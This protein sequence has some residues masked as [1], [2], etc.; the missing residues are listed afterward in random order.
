MSQ[1]PSLAVVIEGGLVQY[2][3]VQD[4]PASLPLP[5]VAVVDY[6]T[7]GA[8]DE[9]VTRF[10]LAGETLEALCYSETPEVYEPSA[11]VLSPRALLAA[12]G[13]A[14]DDGQARLSLAPRHEGTLMSDTPPACG[15]L[16]LD[17]VTPVII[18]L[19][20]ALGLTEA[21]PGPGPARVAV[22][23]ESCGPQWAG[24]LKALAHLAA[25]LDLVPPE[26]NGAFSAAAV[27]STLAAHFGVAREKEM[28]HLIDY[29][30]FEDTAD[31]NTLFMIA[32]HFDDGHGLTSLR[33]ENGWRD[34]SPFLPRCGCDVRFLSREI[35]LSGGSGSIT[36]LGVNLRQALLEG[37]VEHAAALISL[38]A[39]DILDGIG[40]APLRL[41]LHRRVIDLL[42]RDLP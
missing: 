2:V 19:F 20:G 23:S 11:E 38:D 37:D 4:W 22:F 16:T 25:G 40:D 36:A 17:R 42:T 26:R 21:R 12:I 1:T 35:R 24:V 18:A 41:R 32:F 5:R 30:R 39:M 34:S 15:V 33:I 27:L 13:E 6:D 29:G 3:T 31:F 9:D 7:E 14:V 10:S 28:R 8:E